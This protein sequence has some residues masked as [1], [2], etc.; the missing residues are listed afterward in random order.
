MISL[1]PVQSYTI[2]KTTLYVQKN[3]FFRIAAEIAAKRKQ[4]FFNN[5]ME[6]EMWY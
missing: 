1:Y 2:M 6:R 3:G 4:R 5:I